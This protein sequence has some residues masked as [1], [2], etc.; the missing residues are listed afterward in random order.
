MGGPI[1]CYAWEVYHVEVALDKSVVL[2]AVLQRL[3]L[4]FPFGVAKCV[5]TG[6]SYRRSKDLCRFTW[7]TGEKF[8]YVGSVETSR[9][10]VAHVVVEQKVFLAMLFNVN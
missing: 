6:L 3:F 2:K 5:W 9:S 8:A 10:L 4:F 7:Y 1:R